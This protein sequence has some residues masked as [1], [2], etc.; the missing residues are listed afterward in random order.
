MSQIINLIKAGCNVQISVNDTST[1]VN[2]NYYVDRKNFEIVSSQQNNNYAVNI[3]GGRTFVTDN[4]TTTNNF[5]IN[6][7]V[8]NSTTTF[9]TNIALLMAC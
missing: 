7:V 4:I 2:V 1:G 8:I 5:L 9:N 3:R 6:G